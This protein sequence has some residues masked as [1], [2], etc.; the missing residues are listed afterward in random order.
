MAQ[1][2]GVKK[3]QDNLLV[4]YKLPTAKDFDNC[5]GNEKIQAHLFEAW[6]TQ[7]L[8][9]QSQLRGTFY[10]TMMMLSVDQ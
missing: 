6:L 5:Q 1:A 8:R 4:D 3:Y 2:G 9:Q 7:E 10:P